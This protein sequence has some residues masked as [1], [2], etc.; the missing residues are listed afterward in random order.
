M[1]KLD[2]GTSPLDSPTIGIFDHRKP[3]FLEELPSSFSYCDGSRRTSA[4]VMAEISGLEP[5]SATVAQMDD[6]DLRYTCLPCNKTERRAIH[7]I[8]MALIEHLQRQHIDKQSFNWMLDLTL[9]YRIEEKIVPLSAADADFVKAKERELE[10][11]PESKWAC[12]HCP[13]HLTHS[14]QYADVIQH[15]RETHGIDR[16]EEV[17]DLI[18]FRRTRKDYN[19]EYGPTP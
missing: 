11:R 13:A 16:P 18:S 17:V 9:C 7:S 4:L 5:T 12:T 2:V 3:R 19:I 8:H 15:V 14:I 10:R 6:L 1:A